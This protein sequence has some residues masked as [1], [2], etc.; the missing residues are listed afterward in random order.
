MS[1]IARTSEGNRSLE[2]SPVYYSTIMAAQ[3]S[4][5]ALKEELEGYQNKNRHNL[6]AIIEHVKALD[7]ILDTTFE[8]AS[9]IS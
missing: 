2:D 8:E 3:Q 4:L 1:D 6:S 5:K 7:M 9:A